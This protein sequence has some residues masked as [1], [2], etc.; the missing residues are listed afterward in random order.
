MGCEAKI[1]LRSSS[2]IV[3]SA[4]VSLLGGSSADNWGEDSAD[5]SVNDDLD[6]SIRGGGCLTVSVAGT[7]LTQLDRLLVLAKGGVAGTGTV[8]GLPDAR[9]LMMGSK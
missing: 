4:G 7:G 2:S 5:D 8:G 9:T 3:I 6:G 1:F